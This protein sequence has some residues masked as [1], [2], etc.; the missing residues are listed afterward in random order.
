MIIQGYIFSLISAL[1][2][3][4]AAI[5]QKKVLFKES[6]LNFSIVFSLFNLILVL[7]LFFTMDFSKLTLL[8]LL[9]LLVKSSLEAAAFVCVLIGIKNMEIS[10][11]LPLLILTPGLVAISAFIFLGESLTFLEI[12]GLVLLTVGIY[13]LSFH[14]EDNK[15]AILKSYFKH[16]IFMITALFLFTI[17]AILDK[18][19]LSIFKFSINEFMGFQHLFILIIFL[20]FLLFSDKNKTI[21]KTFKNS[22]KIILLISIFTIIYRYTNLLA[23]QIAPVALALALKRT[24][25]LIAVIIGGKFFKENNLLI[26]IIATTIMTAGAFLIIFG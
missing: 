6:V 19:L 21:K 8:N 24:S 9:I 18:T 20:S 3:A 10:K 25:V 7:P 4:G 23:V 12:F 13:L 26:R 22:W 17:T 1:F 15:K 14:K 5:G 11:A 2:S 16:Y